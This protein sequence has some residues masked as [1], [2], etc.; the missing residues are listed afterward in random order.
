MAPSTR[1]Y[2][3]GHLPTPPLLQRSPRAIARSSGMAIHSPGP[4]GRPSAIVLPQWLGCPHSDL[5]PNAQPRRTSREGP[6]PETSGIA[7]LCPWS[8]SLVLR[9]RETREPTMPCQPGNRNSIWCGG[10]FGGSAGAEQL[11]ISHAVTSE[12]VLR[13]GMRSD[14]TGKS[15]HRTSPPDLCT[16]A[17]RIPYANR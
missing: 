16:V 14:G 3:Y 11:V 10:G 15:T 1:H 17:P 6:F 5:P 12:T 13:F 2:G 4:C 9:Y 7:Q 8:S